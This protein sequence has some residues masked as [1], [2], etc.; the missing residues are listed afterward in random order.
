MSKRVHAF[1]IFFLMTLF[2]SLI[3]STKAN[4]GFWSGHL[5]DFAIQDIEVFDGEIVVWFQNNGVIEMGKKYQL[6]LAIGGKT[7]RSEDLLMLGTSALQGYSFPI[8]KSFFKGKKKL[9]AQAN[10]DP[11]N[12]V[13][14]LDE[15]NVFKKELLFN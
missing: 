13:N 8:K 2:L 9:Y 10:I 7:Y 4:N 5:P 11:D 15:N 12:R 14:E 6:E 3:T 1:S